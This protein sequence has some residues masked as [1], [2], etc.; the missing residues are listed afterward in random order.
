MDS[1]EKHCDKQRKI[2][3]KSAL[4]GKLRQQGITEKLSIILKKLPCY[5]VMKINTTGM[6][7]SFG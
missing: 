6:D 5:S 3:K 7:L 4:N 2:K 1:K